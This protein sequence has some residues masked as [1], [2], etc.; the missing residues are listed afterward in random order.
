MNFAADGTL[1]CDYQRTDVF[2][3]CSTFMLILS[4]LL[5]EKSVFWSM[6]QFGFVKWLKRVKILHF[7]CSKIGLEKDIPYIS[8]LL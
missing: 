3:V 7:D 8:T 6:E 1:Q 5:R 4:F 2:H